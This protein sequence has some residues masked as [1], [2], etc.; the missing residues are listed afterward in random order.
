MTGIS[1]RTVAT[2]LSLEAYA[3]GV[4]VEVFARLDGPRVCSHPDATGSGAGDGIRTRDIQLGRLAL[5]Q[6]SYS[7]SGDPASRRR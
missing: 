4:A 1:A 3:P 7:R 6:L 5:H 2:R